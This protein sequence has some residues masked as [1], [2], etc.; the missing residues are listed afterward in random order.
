MA[1]ILVIAHMI[2]FTPLPLVLLLLRVSIYLSTINNTADG[3][4]AARKKNSEKIGYRY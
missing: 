4:G 1:C 3:R 2:E